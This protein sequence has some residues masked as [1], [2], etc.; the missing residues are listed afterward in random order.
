MTLTITQGMEGKK[1]ETIG[2]YSAKEIAKMDKAFAKW[3]ALQKTKDK[4]HVACYD[5][6][7]FFPERKHIVIDFGDYSYFGLV[8][9]TKTEWKAIEEH[10]D[11][12]VS[13]DV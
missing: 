1:V 4:Y 7:M 9:A 11:K 10:R 13:L 5:R 3:K 2:K 12:P 8:K 6:V